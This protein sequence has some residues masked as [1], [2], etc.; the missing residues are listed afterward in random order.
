[1]NKMAQRLLIFFVG[2]P[3]LAAIIFLL[4]QY[5]HLAINALIV[6]FSAMG[7]TELAV[8]LAQKKLIISKT[9]AA[10]LGAMP[11][12]A[13][14]L[15][16]SFNFNSLLLPAIIAVA[17]SW[18]LLSNIFRADKLDATISR[19]AAGFF[20]LLY[21]GILLTWIVR[22]SHLKEN[23]EFII[24]TFLCAVFGC[25][26][27]AWATG[28]LFGKGNQGIIPASPNK[29]IAGFIGGII[30]PIIICVGATQLVPGVFIPDRGFIAPVAGAILGLLTG[31][32]ATLGDLSESAIK[33]SS[34][35]K[36]S[37][38]IMPGRGGI[39]DSID[40]VALAAPVFYLTFRLLFAQ[41]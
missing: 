19:L 21:P 12:L 25:D 6:I 16:V 1:M 27:A 4:P 34:G 30:A 9:E 22:M 15:T 24:M 37:G 23:S 28:M 36:D 33:R 11:P 20:V 10:V 2:P 35:L 41:P 39:L 29:S 5:N 26:S 3:I 32:A 13:M 38:R 14:L 7:A 31:I 17:V 40:S 8:L 18:L